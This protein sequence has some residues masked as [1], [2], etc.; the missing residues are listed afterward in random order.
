[1]GAIKIFDS[2]DLFIHN[3]VLFMKINEQ[4]LIKYRSLIFICMIVFH[5]QNEIW[6]IVIAK[7]ILKMAVTKG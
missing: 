7:F 2:F 5:G 4:K 3:S 6:C 1:M